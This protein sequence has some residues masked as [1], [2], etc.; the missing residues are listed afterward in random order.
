V[1][2]IVTD[3][4]SF[5]DSLPATF[6][7]VLDLITRPH[8]VRAFSLGARIFSAARE[9][10]VTDRVS[11]HLVEKVI[12]RY[13]QRQLEPSEL[14]ALDEHLMG[15][16]A[17]RRQMRAA[18]ILPAVPSRLQ[19]EFASMARDENDHLPENQ[20]RAYLA[21]KL[22]AVDRELAESHLE[23]CPSCQSQVRELQ[24]AMSI[25][26]KPIPAPANHTSGKRFRNYLPGW[27]REFGGGGNWN[28]TLRFA[29]AM[30]LLALLV[31]G[32][33]RWRSSTTEKRQEFAGGPS[34]TASLDNKLPE[35]SPQSQ[36]L[37]AIN[38]GGRQI[39]ADARGNLTGVESLSA[40]EQQTIKNSLLSGQIETPSTLAE[41]KGKA[42]STMGGPNSNPAQVWAA[43][44]STLL[45]P[46]AEVIAE[47]RPQFKWKPLEGAGSY[48]VI[49]NEPAAN[50]R[51]VAVSPVLTATRWTPPRALPRGRLFIWQ[52]TATYKAS[53][54]NSQEVTAPAPE[55]PETKFR[56]LTKTQAEELA[57]AKQVY[58]SQHLP[59]GLLYA[60]LGLLKDAERELQALA[61]RNP[62]QPIVEKLLRDLQNKRR[63][64]R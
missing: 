21:E 50:Y 8:F 55:A 16:A 31:W 19:A 20:L 62:K 30:A 7:S 48:V 34:P 59:M 53:D 43:S 6:E 28:L 18:L 10:F 60:R 15:C 51:E 36:P 24:L 11:E 38:D 44:N 25:V 64:I 3:K 13:R 33:M 22:D 23:S 49:I 39:T 46:F 32:V 29:G 37:F 42:G 47:D 54:G 61:A 17:C 4:D 14:L 9:V 41:L 2:G 45:A 12:E 1:I 35:P 58:E 26:D 63:A 27:I 57:R 56:V 52:V 40:E 5:P